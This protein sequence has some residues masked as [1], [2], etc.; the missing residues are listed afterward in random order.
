M[1]TPVEKTPDKAEGYS[2][3]T[4]KYHVYRPDKFYRWVWDEHDG[5]TTSITHDHA[6]AYM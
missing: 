5:Y 2:E 6:D 3:H 4:V 1:A